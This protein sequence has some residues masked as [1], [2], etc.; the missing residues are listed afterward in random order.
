[1]VHGI[2]IPAADA[3]DIEAR[4]YVHLEDYQSAV[5]GW[6]EAVDLPDFGCTL[7]VNEDGLLRGLPYNRRA[8]YLWWY[9]VPQARDRARLVGDVVAVGLAYAEIGESTN[10][11]PNSGE[12]LLGNTPCQV[13]MQ[14]LE[15]LERRWTPTGEQSYIDAMIGVTLLMEYAPEWT[16][17]VVPAR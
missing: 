1:M 2:Y 3:W 11:S 4:E 9:H 15:S 10:L 14:G 7:F 16:L 17:R 6:I 8:T 13:E 5:D 12:L